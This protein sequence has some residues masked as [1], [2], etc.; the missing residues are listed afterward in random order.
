MT[1]RQRQQ[2][3]EEE[4]EKRRKKEGGEEEE[5][6]RYIVR[7]ESGSP[8]PPIPDINFASL[9]L[10]IIGQHG[11]KKALVDAATGKHHTYSD[12]CAVVPR[13]CANLKAAGVAAGDRVMVLSPN[14]IDFPIASL[15]I[16]LLPAT[17]VPVNP[18]LS[19]EEVAQVVKISGV[20]WAVVEEGVVGLLE[21]VRPLLS[22]AL[23]Q[24]WVI[25]SSPCHPSL[26]HLMRSE[27]GNAE[28]SP[29]SP[30]N[31]AALMPFSS[32]TTGLPKGVLLPHR[33]LV[34]VV[35]Q[36][37]CLRALSEQPNIRTTAL[38]Q[39]LVT[40]PLFH[41]Y[42]NNITIAT[43]LAGGTVVL[44]AKFSLADFLGAIERYKITYVPIVPHIANYM[45]HSPLLKKY[46]LDSLMTI[47]SGS[48]PITPTT[49]RTLTEKTGR[50]IGVGYG[51]TETCA[52]VSINSPIV[53]MKPGSVGRILPYVEVKIVSEGTKHAL[54]RGKEG[55]VWVRGPGVMLGYAPT[56]TH[57]THPWGLEEGGWLP[58][59]DLGYCDEEGFLFITERIKDVMKVKGF[60]VAPSEVEAVLQEMEG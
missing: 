17:C 44:M 23:K 53:G 49:A 15:A 27:A 52:T 54:P 5:G 7:W 22:H 28:D 42:A 59:G 43:L 18:A 9:L 3:E 51:L 47:A 13:V 14:H 37:K 6:E 55:E 16:Q 34:T 38:S 50:G 56:P 24:V 29:R 4:E 25:G 46:N 30:G 10:S 58:T 40:L 32:G 57:P 39:V 8:P 2:E 26:S 12:I 41:I 11:E 60:Q 33:S 35:M 36:N 19:P 1:R 48:A 21:R 20:R 31:I 45:I